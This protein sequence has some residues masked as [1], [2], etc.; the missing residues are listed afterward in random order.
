MSEHRK[1]NKKKKELEVKTD[2]N[3]KYNLHK[4]YLLVS[5]IVCDC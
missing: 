2:Y 5:A 1:T 4:N 3:R